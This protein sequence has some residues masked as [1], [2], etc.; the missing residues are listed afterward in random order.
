MVID[1]YVHGAPCWADVVCPDMDAAVAFYG[2]LLGWSVPEGAP[3]FGGYR[4]ATIGDRVVAGMVP[5]MD[6]SMM[7]VWSM[8]I[9]TDDADATTAAVTA[10]GG[11]VMVPP[12]PVGE[13]GIMAIYIDPTGAVIGA[14]QP[15]LHRG[16]GVYAQHGAPCWAELMTRDVD[17]AKAFYSEVFGWN[18]GGGS[19]YHEFSAGGRPVGGVLP[20]PAHMP[21]GVPNCW[22]VY[23]TVDDLDVALTTTVD[24]GGAVH[25]DATTF[26]PGRFA[27][28]ADPNGAVFNLLQ[29][30][31]ES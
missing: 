20:T 10:N 24:L 21:D 25:V 7:T 18:W 2:G 4:N 23:Y 13:L 26:E 1:E 16:S 15:G 11:Q 19:D 14:W 31:A 12:M 28:V 8:Y 6:P 9:K 22:S 17:A 29:F 3:E 27:V 5:P 30:G